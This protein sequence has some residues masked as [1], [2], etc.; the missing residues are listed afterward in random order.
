MNKDKRVKLKFMVVPDELKKLAYVDNAIKVRIV[1]CEAIFL[2]GILGDSGRKLV[3]AGLSFY[4][5]SKLAMKLI[6][7]G[8]AEEI[9]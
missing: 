1:D 4:F 9:K 3:K 7:K 2:T 5:E 8:I 6:S